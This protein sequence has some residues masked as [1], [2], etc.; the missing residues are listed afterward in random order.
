[1]RFPKRKIVVDFCKR[2]NPRWRLQQSFKLQL[3]RHKVKI[4]EAT[5]LKV[6]SNILH[7]YEDGCWYLLSVYST[8]FHRK[9]QHAS[10]VT[11]V[12]FT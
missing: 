11:S 5:S 12:E 7:H 10:C 1:M 6:S 3:E 9:L 8:L 2:I 4:K